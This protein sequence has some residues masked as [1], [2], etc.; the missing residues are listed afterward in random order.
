MLYLQ[1]DE[2]FTVPEVGAVV[3]GT[4]FYGTISEDSKLLIGPSSLGHYLPVT[5]TTIQ[6]NR[7]PCRL[8]RAGQAATLSL[9]N[10]ASRDIR[11]VRDVN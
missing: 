7:A 9:G 8:V 3:G 4:L 11:K 10:V 2:I 1:I 6:R 5:V